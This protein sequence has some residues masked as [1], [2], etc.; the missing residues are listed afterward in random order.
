M[1][2]KLISLACTAALT[3]AL[4]AQVAVSWR[5]FDNNPVPTPHAYFS[6]TYHNA[7]LLTYNGGGDANGGGGSGGSGSPASRPLR[8]KAM[9]W[10]HSQQGCWYVYGDDG[11]C[12]AGYDCSGLVYRAYLA[13][14]INIGRDTYEMLGNR[15][16]RRI[17]WSQVQR[18][19]LAFYGS[20]HVEL[21]WQKHWHRTFGA[22]DTGT[23]V[24]SAKWGGSWHPTMYF[25]VVRK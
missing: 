23:R 11:P 4:V 19:D 16:L 1:I 8:L 22:H 25:K 3:G 21:M 12:S 15:H 14:G 6:Q 13:Q 5:T 10:A 9:S 24:G 20:G 7:T 2:K 18:G 17:S